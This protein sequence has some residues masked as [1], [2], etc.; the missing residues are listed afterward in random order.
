MTR[1][2]TTTTDTTKPEA[3]AQAVN[4]PVTL[5]PEALQAVIA[6]ATKQAVEKATTALKAEMQAALAAKPST[7]ND[8]SERSLRNETAVVRAF[9]KAGFGDLR[10]HEDIRTFNR[11]MEAGFRPLEGSKSI[12]INNLR[13]FCR[14]QCRP[15][16]PEEK[17][18]SK[19]QSEAAIARHKRSAKVIP[20]SAEANPQ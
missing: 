4:P 14:A 10:P 16:T 17:Q 1:T 5:T 7:T 9:R 19:A 15:I 6:E 11:W 18:A 13:L 20:I 2:K 12:K 8:R 3:Q